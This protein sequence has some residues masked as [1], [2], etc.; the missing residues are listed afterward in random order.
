M[1]TKAFFPWELN[2]KMF[3]TSFEKTFIRFLKR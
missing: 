1:Y 3:T 2:I